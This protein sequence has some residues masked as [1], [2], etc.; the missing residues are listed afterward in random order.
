LCVQVCPTAI[1]IRNGTQLECVNCTAC[2][3]ACDEVMDKIEKP[4]GLIRYASFNNIVNN[5]KFT[6]TNRI[7]AYSVVLVLLL[8][9]FFYALLGRTEIETTILR[10]PG[11]L[12]QETTEGNIVNI[13]NIQLANK[14]TQEI[15]FELK[16]EDGIKGNL[17][18]IKNER[19]IAKQSV[20]DSAILIE[21]PKD[22]LKERKTDIE[23]GVYQNGKKIDDVKT[24][25]IG[26]MQ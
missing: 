10:T 14:T 23:I 26:P 9:V 6:F 4:R 11:T 21:I 15:T 12:F 17:K 19:I 16:L 1:D 8:G 13:Y 24:H 22:Q 5:T 18:L 2:I 7:K 3:D 25:F 20:F